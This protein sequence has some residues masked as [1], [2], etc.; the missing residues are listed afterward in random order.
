MREIETAELDAH[1]ATYP[2]SRAVIYT[3]ELAGIQVAKIVLDLL[4]TPD[5]G[6][7]QATSELLTH[8][9]KNKVTIEEYKVRKYIID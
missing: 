4:R 2:Q 5:I 8:L 7:R 6:Y 9:I 1:I 3:I